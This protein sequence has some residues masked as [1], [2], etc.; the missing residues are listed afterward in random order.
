VEQREVDSYYRIIIKIGFKL[1]GIVLDSEN[2]CKSIVNN[3]Q[4]RYQFIV[5]LPCSTHILQIAIK[6]MIDLEPIS[7]IKDPVDDFISHLK[8]TK[9]PRI[10][11]KKF[12]KM[13][14]HTAS[15]LR[16]ISPNETRWSSKHDAYQRI[17]KLY[18][19]LSQDLLK[20]FLH[21]SKYLM[22]LL[23]WS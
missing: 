15:P 23:N 18:E 5:H 8:N 21:I 16:V 12:Q 7:S 22:Q 13:N 17:L 19:Y 10:E 1:S 14:K 9:K 20:K 6:K 11:L 4:K 2:L 3:L